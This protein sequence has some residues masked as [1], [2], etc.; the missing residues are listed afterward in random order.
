MSWLILTFVSLLFRAVYGVMTKVLSTR[1]DASP[2]T[3]AAFLTLI[4]GLLSIAA[5]PLLGGIDLDLSKIN[6][7]VALIVMVS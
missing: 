6:L 3:Q 4:G 7:N 1:I 2:Y 5:S